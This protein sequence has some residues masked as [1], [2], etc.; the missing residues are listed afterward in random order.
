[1]K[2]EL[3][4]D[5]G[6]IGYHYKGKLFT[7]IMLELDKNEVLVAERSMVEGLLQD[8]STVYFENGEIERIENYV[9]D[10]LEG[11]LKIYH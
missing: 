1:M 8:T 3:L 11:P 6:D 7:G 5:V 9:N 4:E 2:S 10:K